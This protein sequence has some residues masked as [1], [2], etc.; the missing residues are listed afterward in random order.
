M[1][2]FHKTSFMMLIFDFW[3][4]KFII[5]CIN[6][7][8]IL[9]QNYSFVNKKTKHDVSCKY[10]FISNFLYDLGLL[11]PKVYDKWKWIQIWCGLCIPWG[12]IYFLSTKTMNEINVNCYW[13]TI[14]NI[15]VVHSFP[16]IRYLSIF[17]L[18]LAIYKNLEFL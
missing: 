12:N 15:N 5:L 17:L 11:Y 6:N 8:V 18:P 2:K 16:I 4:L 7:S 10:I 1:E 14:K 9:N 3:D 13:H